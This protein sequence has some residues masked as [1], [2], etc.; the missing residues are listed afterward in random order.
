MEESQRRRLRFTVLIAAAVV[1]VGA[2]AYQYW[3]P[4]LLV[5]SDAESAAQLLASHGFKGDFAP[6]SLWDVDRYILDGV[7]GEGAHEEKLRKLGAYVGEVVRRAK[8]AKWVASPNAPGG[9]ELELGDG[10]R[11]SP[12]GRVA[13][14]LEAGREGAIAL[15][16]QSLGIDVRPVPQWWLDRPR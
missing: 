15:Y 8:G 3:A 12:H 6:S 13:R 1:L 5:S 16:A 2:G 11:C 4:V 10:T 9:V 7:P 14:R